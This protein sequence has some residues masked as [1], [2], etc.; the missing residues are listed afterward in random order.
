MRNSIS[1]CSFLNFKIMLL[2]DSHREE[3]CGCQEGESRGGKDGEFGVTDA[4]QYIQDGEAVRSYY[5]AQGIIVNI[6]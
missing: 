3:T 2:S 4:N 5:T 1:Q 6:L